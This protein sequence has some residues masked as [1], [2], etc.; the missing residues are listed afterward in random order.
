VVANFLNP[1][2]RVILTLIWLATV[3]GGVAGQQ[4]GV[5]AYVDRNPVAVN[6]SFT[7][8]IEVGGVRGLDGE[9][10]FPAL[11]SFA[12]Y[13]GSNTSTS[14]QVVNGQSAVSLT[15]QYRWIATREGTFEIPPVEVR[16]GGETMLT[17]PLKF[18]VTASGSGGSQAGS[19][20]NAPSGQ[21]TDGPEIAPEDLFVVAEVDRT[22]VYEN[23][24]VLVT[25]RVFTRVNVNS[26]QVTTPPST[27][28]FWSEEI[29]TPAEGPT[30]EQVT[31]NG[32]QY[33]TA[34]VRQVAL[35]PT[36][37]GARTID[38]M[39]LEA[40][41]R[42]ERKSRDVF[43]EFFGGRSLFGSLV[44]VVVESD[45]I[46]IEVLPLPTPRP[47]GFKGFVGDLSIA[48]SLDRTTVD[49]NDA[50]TFS[51]RVTGTGNLQTLV[52]PQFEL[53]A[54]FE[55][56]EPEVSETISRAG[57]V[58]RGS[59]TFDYVLIPRAPG[60]REVPAVTMDYFDAASGRFRSAVAPAIPLTVTGEAPASATGSL[61]AG[62][63]TLRQDI[64]FI[65]LGAPRLVA[66]D[67]RL[68]GSRGFWVVALLPLFA[69]TGALGLRRHQDR[70]YGD[71]AYARGRRAG[72]VA[73]KRMA[74]ARTLA[75]GEDPKAFY[76]EAARALQGFLAD[77]LNIAEAGLMTDVVE[78]SLQERGVSSTVATE[79]LAC[80]EHCDQKR[81][82]PS[83]GGAAAHETFL[84]RTEA[85]MTALDAEL[86]R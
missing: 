10:G 73:K 61:R 38:P 18:T 83:D 45:P 9:P 23:Q 41:V 25:Y 43:S 40:R 16:A 59:K 36:G 64:R 20:P 47:A 15:L 39:G 81:F 44:P 54:D 31:R 63:E 4:V 22:R 74:D 42:V 80:I 84:K 7:F 49:A 30:V 62:V 19:A 70:L 67:R 79:Y 48:T 77:K 29:P 52:A 1:T 6:Q 68:F 75:T 69:V 26:Y 35:F 71:V 28:G 12:R 24:P 65:R 2:A 37:P 3:P 72:R 5:R 57:G 13:V 86:K 8:S 11:D 32:N 78:R 53:P 56:F 34:I 46:D 58:I 33:A 21:G 60:D 51:V 66:V 27:E 85:A 14:V 76:A 17:E 55:S 50:V 82:A